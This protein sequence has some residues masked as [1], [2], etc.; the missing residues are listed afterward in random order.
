MYVCLMAYEKTELHTLGDYMNNIA[1]VLC[2][3]VLCLMRR[4]DTRYITHIGTKGKEFSLL[5]RHKTY[6]H[7]KPAMLLI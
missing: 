4:Q 7:K 6:I 3:Y 1:G 2:M 5:I